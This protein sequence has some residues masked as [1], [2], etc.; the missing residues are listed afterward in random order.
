MV[1]TLSDMRPAMGRLS[2]VARYWQPMVSPAMIALKPS[3]SWTYPGI[4]AIGR[5]MHRKAIKV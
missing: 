4:T 1:P 5:P 3:C 2:R